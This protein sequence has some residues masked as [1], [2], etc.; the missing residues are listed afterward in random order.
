MLVI[1]HPL[2][3]FQFVHFMPVH[4]S[5]FILLLTFDTTQ[6]VQMIHVSFLQIPSLPHLVALGMFR[7]CFTKFCISEIIQWYFFFV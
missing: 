6:Q 3:T 7:S 5:T 4:L 2:N 1:L